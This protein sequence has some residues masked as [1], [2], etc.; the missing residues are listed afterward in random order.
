MLWTSDED[1]NSLDFIIDKIENEMI[2][3]QVIATNSWHLPVVKQKVTYTLSSQRKMTILEEYILKAALLDISEGMNI[4]LISNLLGL[5]EVFIEA[6]IADLNAKNVINKDVLPLI[7]L[8]ETGKKYFERGMVPDT[9]TTEEIEYFVDRKFGMFYTKVK[10][11][12]AYGI[13][14]NYEVINSSIENIKKFINR[15]FIVNVGKEQG[16]VIEHPE[17]GKYITSFISAQTIEKSQTLMSEIWV[18]DIVDDKVFCRIWDHSK[19]VFRSDIADFIEKHNIDNKFSVDQKIDPTGVAK[20]IRAF[21][22]KARYGLKSDAIDQKQMPVKVYRGEDIKPVFEKCLEI[23]KEQIII[24]SPWINENVVDTH[25]INKFKKLAKKN[26][27]ILIGWGFN[28]NISSEKSPLSS[29]L[30]NELLNI[31]N[32]K[33]IPMVCLVYLGNKHEKEIV[34]DNEIHIAGS[35]NWLSYRGDYRPRGESIYYIQD[36]DIVENQR[37]YWENE[38]V[39]AVKLDVLQTDN[40]LQVIAELNFLF[41][42]VTGDGFGELCKNLITKAI[43]E[44]TMDVAYNIAAFCVI[45]KQYIFEAV[46]VVCGL[47]NNDKFS[48]KAENI[49][50]YLK[51]HQPQ[52]FK[53]LCDNHYK[54]LAQT[55]E[56]RYKD[57]KPDDYK[58]IT[59]NN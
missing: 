36:R 19:G 25:M 51:F 22:A 52:D 40:S 16:K 35:F 13:Y 59:F 33:G 58:N 9:T 46:L 23:P 28:N 53:N 34:I 1:A 47:L 57:L 21:M 55:L 32:D 30:I 15:N 3:L 14:A 37:I 8:T 2:G 41:N 29:K 44:K 43:A 38:F 4:P 56:H 17:L 54:L 6:C 49:L 42:S 7:E 39:T 50:A 26:V 18:Y 24:F 10:Q 20:D 12:N 5:D 48:K 31:K 27:Q 45:N 11:D